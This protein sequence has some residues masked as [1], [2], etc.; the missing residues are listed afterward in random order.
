[1]AVVP[2]KSSSALA[3]RAAARM[4]RSSS[5]ASYGQTRCRSHSSSGRSSAA[6]R[7]SV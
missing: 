7:H 6:P 1:M 3:S 2:P 5:A 4:A